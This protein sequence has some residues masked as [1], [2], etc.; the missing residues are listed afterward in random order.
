VRASLFQKGLHPFPD[1]LD[2]LAEEPDRHRLVAL[3]R[4]FIGTIGTIP[5][6]SGLVVAAFDFGLDKMP[7]VRQKGSAISYKLKVWQLHGKWT[8]PQGYTGWS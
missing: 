5:L 4:H 7:Q 8:E 3:Q 6:T 2:V 1:L